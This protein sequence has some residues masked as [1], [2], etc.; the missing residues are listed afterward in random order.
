M[1]TNIYDSSQTIYFH[2][3]SRGINKQTIF[4]D[5][6]DYLR[7]IKYI[8]KYVIVYNVKIISYCLMNN[9]VHMLLYGNSTE[10]SNFMKCVNQCYVNSYNLRYERIGSLIQNSPK[11]IPVVNIRYLI[12]VFFYVLK[13]PARA[14]ICQADKYAWN[15]YKEYFCN[16]EIIDNS[17]AKQI[18]GDIQ[19]LQYNIKIDNN[20]NVIWKHN[21]EKDAFLRELIYKKYKISNMKQI[22]YLNK[23][24]RNEVILI[25]KEQGMSIK[26]ICSITGLSRGIVQK[27]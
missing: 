12:N 13:N 20:I 1:D 9:H 8:T 3:I 21:P 6:K 15:S 27:V 14:N 26:K 19:N 5:D 10:I 7:Y 11:K 2:V 18:Y 16:S 23:T 24:L 25:L 17:L 4:E 22:I